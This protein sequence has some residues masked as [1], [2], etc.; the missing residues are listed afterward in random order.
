[1]KCDSITV[2]KIKRRK[3]DYNKIYRVYKENEKGRKQ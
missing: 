2:N 3:E 1:M